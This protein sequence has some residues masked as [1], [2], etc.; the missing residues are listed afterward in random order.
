MADFPGDEE[1]VDAGGATRAQWVHQTYN[2]LTHP[3]Y[4]GLALQMPQTLNQQMPMQHMSPYGLYYQ[5]LGNNAYPDYSQQAFSQQSQLV[6]YMTPLRN[7]YAPQ[8]PFHRPIFN[9]CDATSFP[10]P[11]SF[12]TTIN[13][14]VE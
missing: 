10:V 9:A 5:S 13:A 8:S 7:P 4:Y 6:E 2:M 1:H 14:Y 12:T 11:C 3:D